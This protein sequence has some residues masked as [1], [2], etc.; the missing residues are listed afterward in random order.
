MEF[1]VNEILQILPTHHSEEPEDQK[2]AFGCISTLGQGVLPSSS[3]PPGM[4]SPDHEPSLCTFHSSQ[5]QNTLQAAPAGGPF[6]KKEVR[7]KGILWH[8]RPSSSSDLS[9]S[10][11]PKY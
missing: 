11:C 8:I 3:D 9:T 4:D 7:T 5:F 6:H 2:R 10:L 1:S